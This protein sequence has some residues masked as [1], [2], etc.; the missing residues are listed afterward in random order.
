MYIYIY[1]Y[2]Y[3]YIYIRSNLHTHWICHNVNNPF[4]ISE[5]TD[6]APKTP[7]K[8][9]GRGRGRGR[10][11]GRG[12][13]IAPGRGRGGGGGAGS[14]AEEVWV[15]FFGAP[16]EPLMLTS[17]SSLCPF[18]LAADAPVTVAAPGLQVC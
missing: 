2:I 14:A 5:G 13:K 16:S 3:I 9:R 6:G 18:P 4:P 7:P 8:A 10:G 11:Q 17:T 12:T 15:K 1:V